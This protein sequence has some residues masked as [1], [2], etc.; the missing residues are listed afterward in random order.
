VNSAQLHRTHCYRGGVAIGGVLIATA[1]LFAQ[2]LLFSGGAVVFGWLLFRQY[3]F[4]REV[5]R[6][7][8]SI[9]V[10][11]TTTKDQISVEDTLVVK[12][13][14]TLSRV[15]DLRLDLEVETPPAT[16]SVDVGP[17]A[18]VRAGDDEA[19][20]ETTLVWDVAGDYHLAPPLV[21]FSD[22]AGLFVATS[23]VGPA[24]RVAVVPPFP[25]QIH[26]GR[27]GQN[28]FET[29]EGTLYRVGGGIESDGVHE[30]VLGDSLRHIDWRA[31]ARLGSLHIREFTPDE[32]RSVTFVVDARQT[33]ADGPVGRTKL[34]YVRHLAL[35]MHELLRSRHLTIGL[36]VCDE[37]GTTVSIPTDI[38]HTR[39]S[40][41]RTQLGN[42]RPLPVRT[43]G[44]FENAGRHGHGVGRV[45]TYRSPARASKTTRLL[46]NDGSAFAERLR[47]FFKPTR[48]GP[49]AASVEADPLYRTA[50]VARLEQR[51]RATFVFT[52]DSHRVE[53]QKL[54]ATAAQDDGEVVLFLTPSVLFDTAALSDPAVAYSRFREFER[55]CRELETSKRV[56]VYELGPG[57]E[58][59]ELLTHQHRARRKRRRRH[60]TDTEPPE[61]ATESTNSPGPAAARARL[62]PASDSA[63]AGGRRR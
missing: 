46:Q 56:T 62:E 22:R 4:N 27:N 11:Q 50:N 10:E 3:W 5:R 36:F 31:T 18:T 45:R 15:T 43:N 35:S 23:P 14:V 1:I 41:V 40:L 20:G 19:A 59:S 54:T 25:S 8:D 12:V 44:Q 34:D 6:T 39:T 57:D 24:T 60:D 9:V 32:G 21:R 63:N 30:Y 52:D 33:M 7:L 17:I 37:S 26:I 48:V 28:L 58:L 16:T 13:G 49:Q 55:F 42:I 47:P 61:R 38:N 29:Q 53:L 51:S 2:P